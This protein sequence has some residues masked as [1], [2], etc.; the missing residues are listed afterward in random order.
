M[1]PPPG[2]PSRRVVRRLR[3]PDVSRVL[4]TGARAGLSVL[5]PPPFSRPWLGPWFAVVFGAFAF[6]ASIVASRTAEEPTSA[7][8]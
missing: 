1:R 7:G 5:F 3:T 8:I 6:A 4:D 2:E